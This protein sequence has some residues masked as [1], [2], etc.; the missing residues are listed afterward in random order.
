[1]SLST[2]TVGGN[3]VTLVS[4]PTSPGLRSFDIEADDS[5]STIIS[6]YT[7]Q[8][9]TMA[10]PGGDMLSGTCTLAPLEQDYADDWEAFLLQLRGMVNAFQM[11]NP[12]KATPRGTPLGTPLVDN[13]QTGANAAMSQTL[14]TKGWQPSTNGLLLR[15]DYLQIGFR[16]HRVLDDVN[17]DASGNAAIAIWPS[18]REQPIDSSAV[19]TSNTKGLWRLATNKRKWSFDITRTTQL[20]FQF[21]EY[22]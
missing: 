20:S 17:S 7:G 5:A 10:W 3:A 12:L 9:Q 21:Q 18:L 19:T 14:G 1:M 6:P 11:G 22:R 13:S 4:F 15:G 2:I 16:L 8:T